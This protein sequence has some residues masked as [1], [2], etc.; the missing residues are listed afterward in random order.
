LTF[1]K[2]LR[3]GEKRASRELD[4]VALAQCE[5]RNL[6]GG[7]KLRIAHRRYTLPFRKPVRT[8]HGLWTEREGLIVKIESE[9]GAF[10]FG[11]IAPISWFGTET[12]EEAEEALL[13]LGGELNT[14]QL[15]KFPTSLVSLRFGLS[16][17]VAQLAS[18]AT[19]SEMANKPALPV[20]A[21]LPSGK[22]AL[23]QA[24]AKAELGFRTFKWKVG[25]GDLRDELAILDD[26]LGELPSGSKL[27]LDA[28]GAWDRK[29]AERWLEQSAGRPVE[30][31]EQPC[32]A[33]ASASEAQ[34]ARIDDLLL[35]LAY[36][37]PTPIALD[38]SVISEGDVVRWQNRGWPGMYVI[39][40]V[41]LGDAAGVIASLERANA[42][43]IFSSALETAVGA[44][45]ALRLAFAFGGERR[46]LG[47]GVWPL[48]RDSRFDALPGMPFVQAQDVGV[49]N[50]EA[51][52]NALS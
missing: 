38:E 7:V 22:D 5:C 36:E 28:N 24:A 23:A 45:A 27:R 8:A 52:W 3:G 12:I 34:R 50:E 11:E 13:A 25:V 30:Y 4:E 31:I 26:L 37:Y 49:I 33:E 16:T 10:G 41:L 2:K 48:F 9:G 20:A 15:S 1:E 47:F 17:A 51:I 46:A 18:G 32:L 44:K 43:V 21:L 42:R 29:Q 40:P 19:A 6:D 14:E 39:K 35:G